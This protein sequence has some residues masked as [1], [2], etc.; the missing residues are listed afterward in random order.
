MKIFV[1]VIWADPEGSSVVIEEQIARFQHHHNLAEVYH[2]YHSVH[3]FVEQPFTS[4]LPE[5][6]HNMARFLMH[7][8]VKNCPK[9]VSKVAI[10]FTLAKQSK[11]LGAYKLARHAF[12]KLQSL[13]VPAQLQETIDLGS[14]TIRAKPFQDKEDLLPMCYRCSTT[15]PLLNSAGNQCVNC[16]QPFEYSFVTFEILPVVEFTLEEGISDEEALRLIHKE[17]SRKKNQGGNWRESREGTTQTL[18]LDEDLPGEGAG[19]EEDP[20]SANNFEGGGDFVP[21]VVGRSVLES[22]HH[23]EV[24]VKKLGAPLGNQYYRS[25]I[26]DISITICSSC[27]KMFLADDYELQVL[28]KGHCP[29]CRKST[30]AKT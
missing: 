6:L 7:K 5:A 8:T 24:L 19:E 14:V 3:H 28:A 18:K 27:N 1:V 29:F 12:D 22:L 11:Q 25:I 2:V 15:N 30:I 9:G 20:F 4:L 17:P 16:K 23:S 13:R 21:V 26:P 10:L